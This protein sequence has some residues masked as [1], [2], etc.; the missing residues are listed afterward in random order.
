[1]VGLRSRSCGFW[2]RFYARCCL[3]ARIERFHA[4]AR[5]IV[6]SLEV[7]VTALST[8]AA[9]TCWGLLPTALDSGTTRRE[10]AV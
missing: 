1:M 9:L 5:G 2:K 3:W 10:C 8:H 4:L 7:N 6:K